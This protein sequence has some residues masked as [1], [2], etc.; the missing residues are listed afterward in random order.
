MGAIL[1]VRL[2]ACMRAR[3]GMVNFPWFGSA[4]FFLGSAGRSR[5]RKA[6][7]GSLLFRRSH[8]LGWVWAGLGFLE[9]GCLALFSVGLV[10]FRVG[11]GF[12]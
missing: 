4:F 3:G 8:R 1:R 12:A 7:E 11:L 5:S 6:A 10:L 2:Q 9:G